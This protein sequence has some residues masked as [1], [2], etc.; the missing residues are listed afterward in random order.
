MTE[1]FKKYVLK[2]VPTKILLRKFKNVRHAYYLGYP[3]DI[4]F[5]IDDCWCDFRVRIDVGRFAFWNPYKG[6]GCTCYF[7]Q[8][9]VKAELNTR[10]NINLK[11]KKYR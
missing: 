8:D 5:D 10:E 3:T 9:E 11:L 1:E 6:H 7:S 2:N 4:S